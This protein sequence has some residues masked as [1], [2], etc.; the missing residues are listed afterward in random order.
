MNIKA[1]AKRANVS[2]ATVSRTINGSVKVTAETAARVQSAIRALNFIPDVNAR[3][4]GS[5]RSSLLGLIISDITNPFFPEL[6][7]AFEDIAIQKGKEVLVANTDYDPLRTVHCVTRMLQRKVDGVA[8]LTSEMDDHLIDLFRRSQTPVVFLDSGIPAEGISCIR[9]DYSA[10]IEL[11]MTHLIALG[12][13]R[14]GFISGPM[15]L[16]SARTRHQAFVS[17]VRRNSLGMRRELV[18]EGNHRPAGG[19]DAMLRLLRSTNPPT[20]VIASND[21]SAIGALGAIGEFGLRV[22][23]DIS[24]IGFDD[25]QLSAYTSPP[26]TTV[27]LP[28]ARIAQAAIDSLL[29]D[30]PGDGKKLQQGA[31][32]VVP[33]LFQE[34]FTTGHVA[35]GRTGTTKPPTKRTKQS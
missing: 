31:E 12:H 30:L 28:H 23:Q 26:L 34:R 9:I 4:L 8:I 3:A 27:R 13:E 29:R 19:H 25:I 14:I 20:A 2:T 21:L 24:L 32:Y 22:P 33:P 7:K 16:R 18:Q 35:D 15:T 11:A 17:S 1:V 10:G 6:V 5:G